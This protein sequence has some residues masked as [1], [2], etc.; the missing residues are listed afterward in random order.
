MKPFITALFFMAGV[1][2]ASAQDRIT[3]AEFAT[4]SEVL[5]QKGMEA[6]S[7]PI[8]TQICLL[9]TSDAADDNNSQ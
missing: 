3:G 6:T 7:H 8:A 5:A 2:M 1:F 9:Y 4:R